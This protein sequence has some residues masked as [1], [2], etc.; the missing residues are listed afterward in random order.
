MKTPRFQRGVLFLF[1]FLCEYFTFLFLL[2]LNFTFDLLN[3]TPKS[4]KN[5]CFFHFLEYGRKMLINLKE[6]Y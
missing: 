5:G 2:L 3:R 6:N 4:E 1:D